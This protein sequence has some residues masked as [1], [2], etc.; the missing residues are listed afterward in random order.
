MTLMNMNGK[1]LQKTLSEQSH[2]TI[3]SGVL[4]ILLFLCLGMAAVLIHSRL[5]TPLNI[6]GK[7]G[8]IFMAIFVGIRLSSGFKY[9]ASIASIG[10]GFM[11]FMPIAGF[12]DPFAAFHY[13]LPGITLD[14]LSLK[15][16][17]WHNKLFFVLLISGLAYMMVP[18][19]KMI[20]MLVA[21]IPYGA[22]IKHG[23]LA[24]VFFFLFGSTGG[25]I[26]A[27]IIKLFKNKS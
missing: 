3:I 20:F 5:K 4:R 6:P 9:A 11:I 13:L 1:M 8:L 18:V 2:R 23:I 26:A 25:L 19:S 24:P 17:S 21:G 15:N 16:K 10:A 14:L 7:H 12:S 27:G 22:F